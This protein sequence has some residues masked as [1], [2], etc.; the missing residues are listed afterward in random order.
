[1]FKLIN[2]IVE[3]VSG[4]LNATSAVVTTS[5]NAIVKVADSGAAEA[6]TRQLAGS[7]N[8]GLLSL[9]ETFKS[10]AFSA[11]RSNDEDFNQAKASDPTLSNFAT[12]DEYL[13]SRM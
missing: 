1:M 2:K 12:L 13:S 4:I 8:H 5:A 9:N 3:P 6:G 10:V 7:I 11:C